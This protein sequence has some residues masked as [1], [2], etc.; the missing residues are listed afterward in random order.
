[1]MDKHLRTVGRWANEKVLTVALA[2]LVSAGAVA[3]A[4]LLVHGWSSRDRQSLDDVRRGL[5]RDG[6]EIESFAQVSLRRPGSSFLFAIRRRRSFAPDQLRI[7]DGPA[8]DLKQRFSF[9]P[10]VRQAAWPKRIPLDFRF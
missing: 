10:S 7:Y 8:S 5:A 9:V 6:Y 4:T 1:M 3:V 2:A